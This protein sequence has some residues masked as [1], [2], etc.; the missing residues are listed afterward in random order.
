M[1][2]AQ[3]AYWEQ[4]LSKVVASDAWTKE[5]EAHSWVPGYLNSAQSQQWLAAEY[6]A[7]KA[8]LTELGMAK[9]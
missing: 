6:D 1:A 7:L 3:V 2:D 5:V 4:A 8:V 9:Q